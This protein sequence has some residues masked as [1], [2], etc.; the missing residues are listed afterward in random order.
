[1]LICLEQPCDFGCLD[2]VEVVQVT[3]RGADAVHFTKEPVEVGKTVK[4]TL[5]WERRF[6]HMQQHSGLLVLFIYFLGE[7]HYR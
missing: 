5:V 4:Q 2:K 6:D 1:M 7:M 3:R